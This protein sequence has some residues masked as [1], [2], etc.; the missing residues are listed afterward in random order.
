MEISINTRQAYSEVDQFLKLLSNEQRNE[1]PQ[2]LQKL[3]SREKAKDY[4]KIIDSKKPIKE[5]GLKEE[6]LAIIALL[7][8]NYWC[9][10]EN[11]KRRLKEVYVKNEKIYQ[12]HLQVQFNPNEIFKKKEIIKER[13]SIVEYKESIIKKLINK[14]KNMFFR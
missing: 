10:D 11:E 1:I 8:L 7:N 14:I 12:E 6:T 2:K 5:Q 13:V 4:E 9:K 3:F